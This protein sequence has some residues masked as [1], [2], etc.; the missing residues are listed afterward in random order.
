MRLKQPYWD[1][2]LIKLRAD[3][4][5]AKKV[6]LKGKDRSKRRTSL[7]HEFK[8]RQSN[9]KGRLGFINRRFKRGQTFQSE[10]SQ[11]VNPRVF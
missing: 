2:E 4:G 5:L 6:F 10:Q 7:K 9:F 8:N 3:M 1:E 11:F